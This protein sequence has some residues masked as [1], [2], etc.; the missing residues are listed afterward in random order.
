MSF[1]RSLNIGLCLAGLAVGLAGPVWA[2]GPPTAG[3]VGDLTGMYTL[4]YADGDVRTWTISSC[5]LGCA[6]IAQQPITN[7]PVTSVNGQARLT[8]NQWTMVINRPDGVQCHADGTT[9]QGISTWT[10]DGTTLVGTLTT[11]RDVHAC[12]DV[13]GSTTSAEAFA[14]M[15]VG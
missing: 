2:G 14:L 12:G 1:T 15:K 4:T 13:A 5:G 6:N 3:P 11:L 9:H 10:W 8:G 7:Q